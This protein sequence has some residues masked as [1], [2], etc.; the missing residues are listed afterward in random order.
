MGHHPPAFIKL[1][2]QPKNRVTLVVTVFGQ[3][4][5]SSRSESSY[6]AAKIALAREA[7]H[8]IR[9]DQTTWPQM[10][11]DAG[12]AVFGKNG[13]NIS[14]PSAMQHQAANLAPVTHNALSADDQLYL[15]KHFR[16]N[17]ISKMGS[18]TGAQVTAAA[19]LIADFVLK[20]P[21]RQT[22]EWHEAMRI[23]T[24][25]PVQ[26]LNEGSG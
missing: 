16:R 24:E 10:V 11:F 8:Y 23:L 21:E 12:N 25:R 15:E 2:N 6:K 18:G 3:Q 17:I 22:T 5:V 20:L 4:I 9:G 7:T 14:N 1:S 19:D 26:R 13:Q